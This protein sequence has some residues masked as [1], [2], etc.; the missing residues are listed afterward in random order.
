MVPTQGCQ[1]CDLYFAQYQVQWDVGSD[2]PI[3]L[4]TTK[5][6]VT[7]GY[8]ERSGYMHMD[9]QVTH[10]HSSYALLHKRH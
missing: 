9:K 8:P 7:E 2:L 5:V 10:F 6:T 4:Q 3:Y 1:G